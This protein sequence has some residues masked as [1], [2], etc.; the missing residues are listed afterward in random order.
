[1]TDP[2]QIV[3]LYDPHPNGVAVPLPTSVKEFVDETFK[4]TNLNV[5]EHVKIDPRYFRPVEVEQLIADSKKAKE[6]L[7]WNPKVKFKDL[8]KIM[9]DSDMRAIGSE[10]IGEGDEILNKRFPDRWWG[11]D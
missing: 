2:K 8:V 10:P 11:V 6:K 1:M 7:G 3:K 4:Y 5:D 9:I